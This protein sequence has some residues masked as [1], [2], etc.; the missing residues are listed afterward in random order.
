MTEVSDVDM[1]STVAVLM[2][3]QLMKFT[4]HSPIDLMVLIIV[5]H[6]DIQAGLGHHV[7]M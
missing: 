2:L 1:D 4:V 5:Y 7:I 3:I 6:I